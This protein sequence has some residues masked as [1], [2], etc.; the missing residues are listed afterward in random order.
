MV[1]AEKHTRKT[2]AEEHTVTFG[3]VGAVEGNVE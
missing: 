1:A 2:I 3:G